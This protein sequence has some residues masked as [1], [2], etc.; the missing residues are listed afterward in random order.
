M[1]L[2]LSQSGEVRT[3]F[4]NIL[5][6]NHLDITAVSNLREWSQGFGLH[7]PA[8]I[9]VDVHEMSD[10]GEA[11]MSE[12]QAQESLQN[13]CTV[14]IAEHCSLNN[15]IQYLQNGAIDC[16]PM[17]VDPMELVLKMKNLLSICPRSKYTVPMEQTEKERII[18]T[19]QKHMKENLNVEMLAKE[20]YMSRSSLQR[21]CLR[22]FQTGPKEIITSY[23]IQHAV[24]MIEFGSN[25][26]ASLA[27]S[28]GYTNVN[29]FIAAFKRSMGTTPK[30]YM[31]RRHAENQSIPTD[32]PLLVA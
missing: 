17:A 30:E 21:A 1:I 10:A 2:L 19:I 31:K 8:L 26:V 20:M 28:V 13:V 25:N 23:K 4:S 16:I 29:N 6:N 12:L 9:M 5:K 15:R 18:T 27:Y 7:L 24:R 32:M 22:H 11:I 3:R 14:M